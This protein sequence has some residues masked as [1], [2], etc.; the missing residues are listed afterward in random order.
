MPVAV[1]VA[2]GGA[3]GALARYAL[4]TLVER[5]VVSV[6]PWDVFA[7]NMS[8]CLLVGVIVSALVDRHHT[9]EWLRVG[10]VLGFVGAYT[11]FS[12]FAQDLYDL[13]QARQAV[14]LALDLG[15]SVG[16][17][18]LAVASGTCLGRLL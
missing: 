17:G 9:P 15:A 4:L 2:V 12:T 7:V 14:V 3:F 8:G 16:G 18:V 5:N 11:T 1:A 6:F 10:L 13:G